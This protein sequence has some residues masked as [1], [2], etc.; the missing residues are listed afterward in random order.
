MAASVPAR[1]AARVPTKETAQA[2]L[3][4]PNPDSATMRVPS[5]A[6]CVQETLEDEADKTFGGADRE[7]AA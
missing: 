2:D 6:G 1:P 7:Q 4:P 3:P 5:A